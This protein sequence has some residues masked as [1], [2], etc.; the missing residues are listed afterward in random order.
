[1][2][3]FLAPHLQKPDIINMYISNPSHSPWHTTDI[4]R[5]FVEYIE[6]LKIWNKVRKGTG[7]D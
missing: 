6:S 2:S 4:L 1:M 5:E 3:V 7:R